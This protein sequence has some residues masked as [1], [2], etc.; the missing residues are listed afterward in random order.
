MNLR[1]F[2]AIVL[3][4]SPGLVCA[5]DWTQFRGESRENRSSE[6]G[7][8]ELWDAE[9]GPPL[10]WIT[11]GLGS[12]YAS[13]AVSE[14][15]IFTTGNFDDGQAA[16]ALDE[17]T[18]E[19]I[20][21]QSLTDRPPKHGY[22]GSRSTPTIVDGKVYLV[23]SDGVAVCLSCDNG[24]VVWQ[25]RFSDWGGK[26][27][28]VWGFSESPLVDGNSVICT[29]GG[30]NGMVVALD[31]NSG[32]EIWTCTLPDYPEEA[33]VN[34]KNL[35]DGAGY[36]SAVISNGG[37]VKQYIQLVGRGLVGIK[38]DDG[39]LLWR[40]KRV[41]N[42]TAN[43][44]T[45]IV[46]GDY[47]FT[48]TGYG[49]GSAL[50]K[51]ESKANGTVEPSEVYWAEGKTIQNK[52]GGMVLVDGHIY[53]GHGNGNGLPICLNMS[54]GE[55]AWGPVRAKG[56]GET[57]T[58]YADGHVIMR[59]EDG[60][61]LLIKATPQEYDLVAT[62]EP[63]FQQGKTWAHPVIANGKLYLRE[64]NKLMCYKLK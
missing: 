20:W 16:I 32:E 61:V 23:T 47:V 9:K 8:Y 44:P 41:S 5:D 62:F 51:L 63:E 30:K 42:G 46:E 35:K 11:E 18:G 50:L 43:I 34:G 22:P 13:V 33:G 14:G 4:I 60:V 39:S 1:S 55:V 38:A 64:Q 17:K 52:H 58:V 15:R 53:C 31:K 25:R 59:R 2:C 10:A 37:G 6:T 54:S 40:Y 29:P 45:A 19:I 24:S 3:A 27:M 26:M 28:S 21:K 12:G 56:K 36:A 48:S 7:L 57:S 49:T